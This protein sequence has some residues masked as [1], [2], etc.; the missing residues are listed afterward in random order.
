FP[1]IKSNVHTA[2]RR[3]RLPWDGLRRLGALIVIGMNRVSVVAGIRCACDGRGWFGCLRRGGSVRE[4]KV[5][6]SE[7][8]RDDDCPRDVFHAAII[9]FR[10]FL[11]EFLLRRLVLFSVS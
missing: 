2:G 5:G 10:V 1:A 9:P 6:R 7:N 3:G 8:G 11:K 4:V